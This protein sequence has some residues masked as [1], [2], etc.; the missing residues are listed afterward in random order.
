[1]RGRA[2]RCWAWAGKTWPGRVVTA[3]AKPASRASRNSRGPADVGVADRVGEMAHGTPELRLDDRLAVRDLA[4]G[5]RLIMLGQHRMG[6]GMGADRD[7]RIPGQLGDLVPAE[8]QAPHHFLRHASRALRQPGDGGE[9]NVFRP[10]A[11][12]PIDCRESVPLL[13]GGPARQVER[14]PADGEADPFE[15]RDRALELEPPQAS[16]A[17]REI[18]G[19]EQRPGSRVATKNRGRVLHV[20]TIAVVE[21]Q[22]RERFRARRGETG[23]HLVERHDV[24]SLGA[25]RPHGRVEEA[26][27]DLEEAVRRERAEGGRADMV[28]GENHAAAARQGTE[29]AVS[30]GGREHAEPGREQA[31]A[32]QEGHGLSAA[33]ERDRLLDRGP[34][35]VKGAA[36]C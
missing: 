19:H 18:R 31:M 25:Q 26:G 13:G 17:F 14:L 28:E 3:V 7:G 11:Q 6:H 35:R 32:R 24:E 27:R 15:P 29:P 30:A 34:A 23:R 1:M 21:G 20:V 10:G 4:T 9:Q 5:A 16:P 12:A 2:C 22:G 33:A 8:A 36:S